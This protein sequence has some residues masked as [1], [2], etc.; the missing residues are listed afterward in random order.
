[1]RKDKYR[2]V[3]PFRHVV[4]DAAVAYATLKGLS[5]TGYSNASRASGAD[6]RDGPVVSTGI[7]LISLRTNVFGR[8][9]GGEQNQGWRDTGG[10]REREIGGVVVVVG[11]FKLRRP[12]GIYLYSSFIRDG[13]ESQRDVAATHSRE[14]RLNRP[15]AEVQGSGAQQKSHRDSLAASSGRRGDA[16]QTGTR[17]RCGEGASENK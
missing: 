12:R 8:P 17:Q 3:F 9:W 7:A 4:D 16:K 14:L 6:S 10:G 2:C 15:A 5:R 11:D 1:M 13:W